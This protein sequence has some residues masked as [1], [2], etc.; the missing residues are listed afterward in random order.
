[1]YDWTYDQLKDLYET[2]WRPTENPILF[3]PRVWRT[4][5]EGYVKEAQ[6]SLLALFWKFRNQKC[7]LAKDKFWAIKSLCTEVSTESRLQML[8]Y[9]SPAGFIYFAF[10]YHILKTSKTLAILGAAQLKG[11]EVEKL[12]SWA[13]DWTVDENDRPSRPL[14]CW[15]KVFG[16][17]IGGPNRQGRLFTATGDSL[18][19]FSFNPSNVAELNI[20][21]LIFASISKVGQPAS[22]DR[23]PHRAG[24]K[25]LA[26]LWSD[27]AAWLALT[28]DVPSA[29]HESKVKSFLRT[30]TADA[31]DAISFIEKVT[32]N[33]LSFQDW[34]EHRTN[35]KLGDEPSPALANIND[36]EGIHLLRFEL[37]LREAVHNRRF[38][39]TSDSGMGLGLDTMHE[40]DRIALFLGAQVPFLIRQS[41]GNVYTLVGECY[42][43]GIMDGEAMQD[44][45]KWEVSLQNIVLR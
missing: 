25:R 1:V 45:M 36:Y 22:Y 27:I 15:Q 19:Q 33:Q 31:P 20:Q 23:D 7:L 11:S 39:I 41:E 8:G 38:F 9:D 29:D 30:L 2:G 44:I 17:E 3:Q 32:D 13:P 18:N 4:D 12:P 24:R 43:H 14:T 37:A 42:V 35:H 34:L 26:R 21:G 16:N 28:K 10:A 6:T 40:N 5:K